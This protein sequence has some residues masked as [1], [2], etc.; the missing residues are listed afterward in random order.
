MTI[1]DPS[2][3]ATGFRM[4]IWIAIGLLVVG[5]AVAASSI[6]ND[7]LTADAAAAR[8]HLV[9]PARHCA[10]DGPPLGARDDARVG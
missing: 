7:A 6:S 9:P 5:A 2:A 10:D 3:F 1:A 4:A 8:D